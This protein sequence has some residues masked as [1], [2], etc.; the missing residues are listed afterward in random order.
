MMIPRGFARS[1]VLMQGM[2]L[3][4]AGMGAQAPPSPFRDSTPVAITHVTVIDVV[5]GRR[6][7]DRTVLIRGKQIARVAPAAAARVPAGSRVV[8]GRGRYLIPGLWDMHVHYFAEDRSEV[9]PLYFLELSVANGVTGVRDMGGL[10]ETVQEDRQ[11]ARSIEVGSVI[12]PRLVLAGVYLEGTAPFEH[13]SLEVRTPAAGRD[14][15]DSLHAWGVDFVKVHDYG[16]TPDVFFAVLA[17]AKRLGM[18]VVGHEPIAVPPSQA[19]DSGYRSIEHGWGTLAACTAREQEFVRDMARDAPPVRPG[20]QRYNRAVLVQ[21]AARLTAAFDSTACAAFA[22]RLVRNGTYVTPTLAAQLWTMRT[23]DARSARERLVAR[24][25]PPVYA[26]AL[27]TEAP[28]LEAESPP[29]R[30]MVYALIRRVTGFLARHGVA[31][32]AGSDVPV[33]YQTPGFA[34]HEELQLL[35]ASG[36][37]PLQALQAATILPA[38]FLGRSDSLGVVAGS[39]ADLVLLDADPLVDIR[40]TTRIRAVVANGRFFDRAAL[41]ALLT[42]VERAAAVGS[43]SR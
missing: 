26:R 16:M 8:D 41:D 15:V 34:L 1:L 5:R 25:F 7:A 20:V 38:R 11:W 23:A 9:L 19:S 12:G 37:T 21:Y 18:P 10:V 42:D 43:P 31:T 6:L 40:N 35:V 3:G 39:S 2:A 28:R 22:A 36:L 30:A 24:Y 17:E 13:N 4:A 32:L 33:G 27:A 14:A 29:E